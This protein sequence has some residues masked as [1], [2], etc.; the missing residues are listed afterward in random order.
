MKLE[1]IH[2]KL[3]ILPQHWELAQLGSHVQVGDIGL[4]LAL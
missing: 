2:R 1:E 4:I 3:A